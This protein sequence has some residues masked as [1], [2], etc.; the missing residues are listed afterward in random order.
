M[1]P[2]NEEVNLCTPRVT[3]RILKSRKLQWDGHV[4][5]MGYTEKCIQYFDGEVSRETPAWNSEND[6]KKMLCTDICCEGRRF[7]ELIEH[8]VK[9][10]VLVLAV[11]NLR[12]LLPDRL[13]LSP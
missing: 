1:I 9:L 3:V 11:L 5:I 2:F 12:V 4:A 7:T 6:N 13:G 8:R 10:R